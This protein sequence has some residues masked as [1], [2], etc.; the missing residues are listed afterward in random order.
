MSALAI[1]ADSMFESSHSTFPTMVFKQEQIDQLSCTLPVPTDVKSEMDRSPIAIH[2]EVLESVFSC[3]IED[4]ESHLLT[5]TPM[6]EDLD[7]TLDGTKVNSKEDWISLFEDDVSYEAIGS[8]PEKDDILDDLFGDDLKKSLDFAPAMKV[9]PAKQLMTPMTPM[10]NTPKIADDASL[11]KRKVNQSR[12]VTLAKNQRK[13]P[14]KPLAADNGDFAAM[15]RARNTEAA[16]RSRARKIE[17]MSQLENKVDELTQD[18][19]QLMKEV[20]RLKKL[21]AQN[22]IVC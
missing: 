14:L 21:L 3:N 22:N 10:L 1:Y 4:R 18:K 11:K 12:C 17:R 7:L 20:E 13:Q 8:L 15:K 19:S 16:R 5:D 9:Q 2:S 6:F